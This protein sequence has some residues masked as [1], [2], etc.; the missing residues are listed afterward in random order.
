VG[1]PVLIVICA[2]LANPLA[3]DAASAAARLKSELPGRGKEAQKQGEVW[4]KEAGVKLDSTVSHSS[5]P[6][7]TN[8]DGHRSTP[9]RPNC[10][11]PML[12]LLR[13][14]PRQTPNSRI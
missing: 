5:N 3:D 1:I 12:R 2:R 11:R 9:P 4:A 14:C 6:H 10:T 7:A 13:R 8:A